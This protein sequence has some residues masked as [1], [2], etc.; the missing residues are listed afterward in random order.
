MPAAT[1]WAKAGEREQT[2]SVQI[3]VAGTVKCRH[4]L[5]LE[6]P[7]RL[8]NFEGALKHDARSLGNVEDEYE[9]ILQNIG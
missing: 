8:T 2:L 3:T 6:L 7:K 4:P 1:L 5:K 9:A